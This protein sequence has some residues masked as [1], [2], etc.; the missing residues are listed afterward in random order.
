MTQVKKLPKILENTWNEKIVKGIKG[1]DFS[2]IQERLMDPDE[3]LGLS[4]IECRRRI[5]FYIDF[6]ILCIKYPE[7]R[8]VPTKEIDSV[9]HA[10]ILDTKSYAK[11]CE[12]FVGEYLH[13][14]PSL[15][16]TKESK[17][18]LDTLF[19]RTE[20]LWLAEYNYS[21]IYEEP[22]RCA[23]TCAGRCRT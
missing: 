11:F 1:V 16:N 14:D 3:G 23:S 2:S 5:R 15:G 21:I 18:E 12:K 17:K 20:E 10:H 22:A 19:K 13:H 4:K 8:I 7:E 6:I 9:W